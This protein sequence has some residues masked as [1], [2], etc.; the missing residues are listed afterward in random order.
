MANNNNTSTTATTTVFAQFDRVSFVGNGWTGV[1][2]T[3]KKHPLYGS[4]VKVKVDQKIEG[5][6]VVDQLE[7]I[8]VRGED[9]VL[10]KAEKG[11]LAKVEHKGGATTT[12]TIVSVGKRVMMLAPV[13]AQGKPN[14]EDMIQ[15]N[16]V[17]YAAEIRRWK[18]EEGEAVQYGFASSA[19]AS[20]QVQ[21]VEEV[22]VAAA[23]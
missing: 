23:D 22:E 2:V 17:G 15:A 12:Y 19:S 13:D 16:A 1:V 6:T 21:D 20:D 5:L 11:G 14:Y 10:L 4:L 7:G 3:S 8:L 18:T 9:I